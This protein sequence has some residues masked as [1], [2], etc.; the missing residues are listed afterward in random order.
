MRRYRIFWPYAHVWCWF[1]SRV[2]VVSSIF[3]S[4]GFGVGF[5]RH[6][7]AVVSCI[8]VT[9]VRCWLR[10]CCGGIVCVLVFGWVLATLVFGKEF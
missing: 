4:C 6:A 1:R 8:F 2:A 5:G 10:A 7:F 9:R 3:L